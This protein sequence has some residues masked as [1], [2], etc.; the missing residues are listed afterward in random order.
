MNEILKS[1]ISKIEQEK[2]NKKNK[3]LNAGYFLFSQKGINNTSVQDIVDK[4]NIAK[5]T[6][7]LYFKDKYELQEDLIVSKSKELFDNA[8]M[9]LQKHKIKKLD[10]QIIFIIDYVIDTLQKSPLL[11]KII[12]KNMSWGVF[13]KEISKIV[14]SDNIGILD[15]FIKSAEI[16]DIKL[17]NPRVTFYMIIELAS[18]TCF[19]SITKNEPLSIEEYKPYLYKAITNIIYGN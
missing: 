1:T 16:N 13:D 12:G 15:Y 9:E 17:K 4:A 19:T 8:L 2:I 10:K 5:G 18:S 11:V 14:A 6:F 3:L 7:Y